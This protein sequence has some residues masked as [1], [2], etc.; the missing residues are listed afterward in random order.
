MW[1]KE[2]IQEAYVNSILSESSERQ[3]SQII[4]K[5][6]PNVKVKK[7]DVKRK[8]IFHLSDFVDNE[9]FDNFSKIDAVDDFIKKKYKDAIV[10]WKGRTVEVEEL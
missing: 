4:S 5:V 6:F 1:E 2:K 8:L 3:V 7:V 10:E 9:E